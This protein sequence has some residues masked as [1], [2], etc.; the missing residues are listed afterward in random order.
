MTENRFD[1]EEVSLI[2]RRALEADA[3][4]SDATG[5]TLAQLKEIAGEVGIDP[6]RMEAAALAV[7]AERRTAHA[8]H[9]RVTARYE[10]QVVGELPPE[11]RADALRAIRAAMGRQGVVTSELGALSWQARDAFGGRY[12]TVHSSEGRTRIE[13]LGNFRDGAMGTAAGG[14]TVGMAVAAIVL[15]ATGGL[16][17][18]G[19]AAPLAIVAGGTL[20]AWLAYRRWFRK[21]DAALRQVVTEI[22]AEVGA[23]THAGT[24]AGAH[25]RLPEAAKEA[26]TD[27]VT[28][29]VSEP[30]TG[31]DPEP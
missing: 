6:A 16:A 3:G 8:S 2:L 17:A 24:H 9:G 31:D 1:D 29:P 22:A 5:L 23:G 26:A 25:E 15:K 21:E 13:A 27:P 12:V 10:I 4:R 19:V 14:G 11:R 18:L 28:E 20:P 7:Q 30:A